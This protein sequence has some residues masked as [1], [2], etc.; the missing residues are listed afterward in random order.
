MRG[1]TAAL[2]E[3]HPRLRYELRVEIRL[4]RIGAAF[5]AVARVFHAAERN[6]GQREADVVDG[7]HACLDFGGDRIGRLRRARERVG[8]EAERQAVR[9]GHGIVEALELGL[10]LGRSD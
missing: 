7:H 3:L 10:K 6:L 8:G 5:G 4:D 9:L 1:A 2:C